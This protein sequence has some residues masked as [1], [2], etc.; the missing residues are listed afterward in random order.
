GVK[1]NSR[2]EMESA[3]LSFYSRIKTILLLRGDA[4]DVRKD[5]R[6]N[7]KLQ[8]AAADILLLF[9][10]ADSRNTAACAAGILPRGLRRYRI[11]RYSLHRVVCTQRHGAQYDGY[12]RDVQ[13]AG[14]FYPHVHHEPRRCRH[15]GDG[16]DGLAHTRAEDRP[17]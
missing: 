15:H 16:Y 10:R 17:P 2:L 8:P 1:N 3:F 4:A 13:C 9:N 14:I 7:Q 5:A 12:R 11:S 6:E